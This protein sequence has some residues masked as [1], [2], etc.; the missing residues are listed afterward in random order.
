[1]SSCV[2]LA[3]GLESEVDVLAKAHGLRLSEACIKRVAR[4]GALELRATCDQGGRSRFDVLKDRRWAVA[5]CV[6]VALLFRGCCIDVWLQ[7]QSFAMLGK[8][9]V[10]VSFD[11]FAR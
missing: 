3:V 5:Q 4:D 10:L 9:A 8:Q 7:H 6:A 2:R 1:M 11:V